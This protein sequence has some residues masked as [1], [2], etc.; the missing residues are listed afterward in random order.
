MS[1]SDSKIWCVRISDLH[2][3]HQHH[4][5]NILLMHL[6]CRKGGEAAISL[7]LIV[8]QI[9]TPALGQGHCKCQEPNQLCLCG[10]PHRQWEKWCQKWQPR[11]FQGAKPAAASVFISLCVSGFPLQHSQQLSSFPHL[12]P[13]I[14]QLPHSGSHTS[15]PREYSQVLHPVK[16]DWGWHSP[17]FGERAEGGPEGLYLLRHH[18]QCGRVQ[19]RLF[20]HL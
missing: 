5:I 2:H 7:L 8:G 20:I 3:H 14:A 12:F 19:T 16:A 11:A 4:I 13:Q 9:H 18:E 6:F 10:P 15:W 1:L 17:H